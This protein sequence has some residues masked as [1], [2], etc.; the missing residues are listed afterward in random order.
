M[1]VEKY[2]KMNNNH[3]YT[4]QKYP[5]VY[6][7][8]ISTGKN[9]RRKHSGNIHSNKKYKYMVIAE[10]NTVL[11]EYYITRRYKSTIHEGIYIVKAER[12]S[13]AARGTSRAKQEKSWEEE[14]RWCPNFCC[15]LTTTGGCAA[16]SDQLQPSHHDPGSR[17]WTWE[18]SVVRRNP[19]SAYIKPNCVH[20]RYMCR[21]KVYREYK[22]IWIWNATVSKVTIEKPVI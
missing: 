6:T 15:T 5:H 8:S 1:E 21:W 3:I 11:Q 16:S 19:A 14:L 7:L 2:V 12:C 13:R 9:Q 4:G 18:S 10:S 17:I 20:N 22:H